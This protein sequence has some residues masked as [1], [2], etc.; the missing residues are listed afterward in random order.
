MY[1]EYTARVYWNET[2]KAYEARCDEFEHLSA[3]G[4]TPENAAAELKDAIEWWLDILKTNSVLPNSPTTII[5]K[6]MKRRF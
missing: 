6:D 3:F 5:Q 4:V 2:E 1:L